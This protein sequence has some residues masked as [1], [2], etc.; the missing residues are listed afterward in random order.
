MIE[1][2]LEVIHTIA[3]L[4]IITG[5]I[6]GYVYYRKAKKGLEMV[7]DEFGKLKEFIAKI[8]KGMDESPIAKLLV[9]GF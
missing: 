8:K 3:S 4:L 7:K 6:V 9:G 2:I 5:A 1:I